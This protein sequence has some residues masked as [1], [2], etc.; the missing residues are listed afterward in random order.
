MDVLFAWVASISSGISPL[1]VKVSSKSLI[2]NPWLFNL[3]WIAFGIPLIVALA[4]WQGGGL[5]K[6]WFSIAFLAISS[7]LFYALYT[8]SLYKIDVTTMGPLLSLRTVFA[9]LLGVLVL[10]EKISSLGFGLI[11]LIVLMSPLAAYNEKLKA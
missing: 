3:L 8:V 5:P 1:V 7:A 11:T 4:L 9:V 2:K 10:N 6:D